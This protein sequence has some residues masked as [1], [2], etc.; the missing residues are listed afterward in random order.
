MKLCQFLIFIYDL[1]FLE[2][3]QHTELLHG[4]N[5]RITSLSGPCLEYAYLGKA[6]IKMVMTY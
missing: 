2:E 1:F 3:T 4:I 6:T 5:V